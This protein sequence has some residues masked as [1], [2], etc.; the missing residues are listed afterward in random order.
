M[1]VIL[2]MGISINGLIAKENGDSEWTSEE[3]LQGFYDQSKTAGN[4]IMGANTF[5]AAS[6]AGYF[7]FPDALNIVLTKQKI[8]NEWG[9]KVLFV[10]RTPKE[11]L[12][13]LEEKGF[14][15]V[16]IAGGGHLNTSFMEDNLIDEIYLDV[17]P[18]LFG[19]GIPLFAEGDFEAELQLLET[20]KLNED[21]IQ[22]H[23]KV[24]KD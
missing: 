1:K 6:G 9:D 5:R 19:K 12:S 2:Y 17:E 13:L 23:Y 10:N 3:N 8:E 22:L 7:P 16:F 20:K 21:T 4:I 24:L 18:L 11:T 15:T 14:K